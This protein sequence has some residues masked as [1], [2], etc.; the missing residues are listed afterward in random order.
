V[1]R[2]AEPGDGDVGLV[3]AARVEHA[4]VDG[5]AGLDG[6][7]VGAQPLQDLLGVSPGD[8]VLGEAGLVEDGDGGA[9]GAL[10][11][12]GPGLPV[13]LAPGVLEDRILARRG[14]EVGPFPAHL[15]AEAGV[16]LLEQ[17]VGRGP[18]ERPGAL[19]LAVRPRYRVVQAQHLADPVVQPLVVAVERG[20]A[21]DVDRGQVQARLP[22][23]DPL[24]QRL[25]GS[26]G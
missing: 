1:I 10:L 26:P 8:Q 22:R 16:G 11:G 20:E 17:M 5:A 9:G 18:A 6:D 24:S 23:H 14:E 15:A 2:V 4:G 21:P 13:L 19:Q 7:V 12:R 3:G 25:S